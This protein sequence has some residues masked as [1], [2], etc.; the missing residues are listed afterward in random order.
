VPEVAARPNKTGR[1]PASGGIAQTER[2]VLLAF[3]FLAGLL[4]FVTLLLHRLPDL[5]QLGVGLS[6]VAV[7]VGLCGLGVR[8]ADRVD[9]ADV[10]PATLLTIERLA[11]LPLAVVTALGVGVVVFDGDVAW[12]AKLL[13]AGGGLALAVVFWGIIVTN[14]L[15]DRG[16]PPPPSGARSGED[17]RS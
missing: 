10:S 3:G 7:G 2:V 16:G 17:R 13:L 9:A 14:R 12:P 15:P 8:P 5:L 4:G 11:L 6:F 1:R